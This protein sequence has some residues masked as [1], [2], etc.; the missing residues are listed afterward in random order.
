MLIRTHLAITLFFIL[1]FIPNVESKIV[2][3][4]IAFFATF[5]ADVDSRHSTLGKRKIFRPLQFFVKHRTILHSFTFLLLITAFFALFFPIIALGFFVGYGSHLLADS[6]TVRGI[7]AFYPA[8]KIVNGRLKTGGRTEII[9][10]AF[11]VFIDLF[12]LLYQI[13]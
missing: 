3:V 10:L 8:K 5:I 12:L 9:V 6:F 7:R 13:L 2:F 1:I 11:F 4:V